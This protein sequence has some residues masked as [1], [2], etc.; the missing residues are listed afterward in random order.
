LG[1]KRFA[2]T[3]SGAG[4]TLGTWDCTLD[5]RGPGPEQAHRGVVVNVTVAGVYQRHR[6]PSRSARQAVVA[7]A[8]VAVVAAAGEAW[9][10]S[11]PVCGRDRGVWVRIEPGAEVHGAPDAPEPLSERIRRLTPS[12]WLD[13]A[14]VART[15]DDELALTLVADVL[16][17][18]E[19]PLREPRF[20]RDARG[21]VA[22][23]L[24]APPDLTALAEEVGVSPWHLCRTFRAVT[25]E[26]PR[27]YGERLRLGVAAERIAGGCEDLAGLAVSLGFSSHSHLSARFRAVFGRVPSSL[28]CLGSRAARS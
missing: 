10:S 7:D 6:V 18:A 11:H 2:L 15:G 3:A 14:R 26:T 16:Q 19:L 21:I 28:R 5:H 24:A 8:T 22:T 27:A 9:R 20:V 1:Q 4:F 25:G 17:A 23:S 12:A 13:W